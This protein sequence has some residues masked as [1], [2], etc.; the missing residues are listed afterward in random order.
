MPLKLLLHDIPLPPSSLHLLITYTLQMG[1]SGNCNVNNCD[2]NNTENQQTPPSMLEQL[3][4]VQT[5]LST[6]HGADATCT[7]L[8]NYEATQDL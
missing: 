1:N 3:L 7:A 8:T 4:I 2:D 6:S 5:Q